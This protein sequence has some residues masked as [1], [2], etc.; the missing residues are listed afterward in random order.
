MSVIEK[1]FDAA[2]QR[3]ARVVFPELDEPR[4]AAAAE[5]LA[6]HAECECRD[7]FRRWESR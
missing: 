5:R 7:G 4:V 1:A 2:R 6:G 3:P